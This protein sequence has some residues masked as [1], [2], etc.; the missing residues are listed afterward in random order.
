M[1]DF[2]NRPPGWR[3]SRKPGAAPA[4]FDVAVSR[5][6]AGVAVMDLSGELDLATC[7]QLDR[8]LEK[9]LCDSHCRRLVV[10]MG[11][12]RFFAA[13]GLTSLLRA[14]ETAAERQTELR[15]VVNTSTVAIP[16]ALD[17]I[18]AKFRICVSRADALSQ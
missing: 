11:Q 2:P 18:G 12:L 9:E 1:H 7:P 17:N 5:P 16:F 15:L 13:C 14:Q 3:P 8:H 6:V 10:D 4:P